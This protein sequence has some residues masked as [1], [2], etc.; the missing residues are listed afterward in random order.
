V[1]RKCFKILKSMDTYLNIG[2]DI[3]DLIDNTDQSENI[4]QIAKVFRVF[5]FQ[6]LTDM[7]GDIPYSEANR[8]AIVRRPQYDRQEDIYM[9]FIADLSDAVQ[10]LDEN[11]AN[12][13]SADILYGG[14]INKWRRFAN[15]L[16]LRIAMRISNVNP[17]LAQDI[18]QQAIADG[19]IES[20]DD[21]AYISYSGSNPDGTNANGVSEVFQD[22]EING[23]LFTTS[24]LIM[25]TLE[26]QT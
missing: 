13:G 9:S 5:V 17:G 24:F 26:K 21:I 25:T 16:L 19:L 1:F 18:G 22:F 7:Y 2:K 10:L 6:R 4:H 14:D 15:S 8:G 11:S 20:F 12:P 3:T 23:H